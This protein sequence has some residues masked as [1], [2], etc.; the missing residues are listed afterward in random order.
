MKTKDC[1]LLEKLYCS[2]LEYTINASDESKYQYY[3][4]IFDQNCNSFK[5]LVTGETLDYHTNPFEILVP[6]LRFVSDVHINVDDSVENQLKL[7]KKQVFDFV[8]NTGKNLEMD[9]FFQKDTKADPMNY[10][11]SWIAIHIDTPEE[12]IQESEFKAYIS[13]LRKIDQFLED[14]NTFGHVNEA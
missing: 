6:S 14:I 5:S 10:N 13:L 4:K 9:V 12:I 11:N 7:T 2:I 3:S 8:S 1:L